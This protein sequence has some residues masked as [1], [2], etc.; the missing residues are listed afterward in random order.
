MIYSLELV[1]YLG[2]MSPHFKDLKGYKTNDITVA[3]N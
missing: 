2:A 3:G 1:R